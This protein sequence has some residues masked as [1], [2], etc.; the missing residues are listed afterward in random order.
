MAEVIFETIQRGVHHYHKITSFPL[1]IGRAFDNDVI[2]QDVT[3]SP[4]HLVIEQEDDQLYIRNLSTE[5]GTKLGK[6]KLDDERVE[7][8]TP[9]SFQIS[10]IKARLLAADMP[11]E[12]THLQE[13]SGLFCLFSNP[14]WSILL[15]ILTIGL[16]FFEVYADTFVKTEPLNYLNLVLPS[17]WV[18]LGIT[19]VISGITRL[20][21]HRWEIIPAISIASL[22]FLLPLSFDYIGQFLS[23]L[24]TNDSIST[25]LKYAAQFL[26][27][28][29]LI[30]VFI[31]KT[32]NSKWLPAMGIAMLVYSPF[33]AFHLLSVI[34]GITLNSGFSHIPSYSKTLLP[35]DN[36]LNTT[37]SLDQFMKEAERSISSEVKE[38]RSEAIK[39][40][41]S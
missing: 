13:C 30:A 31:V 12:K 27:V 40:E 2:L 11:V 9:V 22:I 10:N 20:A 33:L 8:A 38:M 1:T 5:N 7:V 16:L 21:K 4:H 19:V 6:Q 18:I 26:V 17:V 3:V 24:F 35:G 39:K 28:P 34:K 36:R 32:I 14:I 23:Y 15:L 25:Y 37:I 29:S 41:E